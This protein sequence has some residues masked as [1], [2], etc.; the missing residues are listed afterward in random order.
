MMSWGA[1]SGSSWKKGESAGFLADGTKKLSSQFSLKEDFNLGFA[2]HLM[3]G[4]KY[5]KKPFP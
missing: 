5:R 4:V 2:L 1:M 3:K